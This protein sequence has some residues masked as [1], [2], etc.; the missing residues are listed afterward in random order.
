VARNTIYTIGGAEMP[1]ERENYRDELEQIIKYFRGK[2]VLTV[3]DV[4]RYIG[5]DGRWCKKTFD[6]N[7]KNGITAVALAKKMSAL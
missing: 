6:I 1:R 3:S 7:P 5:R 4:S 2:R